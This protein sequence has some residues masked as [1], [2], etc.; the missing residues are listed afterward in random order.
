MNKLIMI[1]RVV[2]GYYCID[3][4]SI[5]TSRRP[6][7]AVEPR[8]IIMYFGKKNKIEPRVIAT[9]YGRNRTTVHRM[10]RV[11]AEQYEVDK[12]YRTEI[13]EINDLIEME[14]HRKDVAINFKYLLSGL[15]ADQ[16][17]HPVVEKLIQHLIARHEETGYGGSVIEWVKE[18][19][20]EL[21]F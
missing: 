7:V 11:V 8:K 20:P 18:N 19:Y 16:L 6:E 13:D 1:E 14:L 17:I 4:Q 21:N 3:P 5:H 9:F 12:C 10:S 2:C 15:T